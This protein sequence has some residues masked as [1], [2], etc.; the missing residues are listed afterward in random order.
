VTTHPPDLAPVGEGDR[1]EQPSGALVAA[2]GSAKHPNRPPVKYRESGVDDATVAAV[3]KLSE[4]LEVIENARG[5]LYEFHRL[6][7]MGDLA[8]Q[9]ALRPLR[10]AGPVGVAGEIDE[11][12]VGRDVLPG[13]WTF[14]IVESYDEQYYPVFRAAEKYARETLVDGTRHLFE[15]EMKAAEQSGRSRHG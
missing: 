7:G 10:S 1:R 3:G 2:Y 14:Q 12:L 4:A 15:A 9:D 13:L 6:S 11:A 5:H 8:L